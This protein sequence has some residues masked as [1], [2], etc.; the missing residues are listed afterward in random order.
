M[1]KEF[2]KKSRIEELANTPTMSEHNK[3]V[4]RYNTTKQPNPTIAGQKVS[5]T[6][7]ERTALLANKVDYLRVNITIPKDIKEQATALA[8]LKQ[9]TLSGLI[10]YALKRQLIR[11]AQLMQAFTQYNEML[12]DGDDI[13]DKIYGD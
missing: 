5:I 12:D 13:E 2:K 6:E 11:N 4:S 7:D 10:T 1:A 8:K 3:P 9:T